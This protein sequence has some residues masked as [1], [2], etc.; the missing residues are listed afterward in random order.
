MKSLLATLALTTALEL[1]HFTGTLSG[2]LPGFHFAH[3]GFQSEGDLTLTVFD[4]SMRVSALS[5]ARA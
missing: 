3:G 4:G 5:S 1:P 2:T